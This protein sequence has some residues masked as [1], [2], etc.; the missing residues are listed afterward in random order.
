MFCLWW[1]TKSENVAE[2]QSEKCDNEGW[3]CDECPYYVEHPDDEP[4]SCLP[5]GGRNGHEN[6]N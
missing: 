2:W 5:G 4:Y 3:Y 6:K 1:N